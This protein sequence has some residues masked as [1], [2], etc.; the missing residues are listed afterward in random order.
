MF[1]LCLFKRSNSVSWS[2]KLNLLSFPLNSPSASPGRTVSSSF[3][4]L[5]CHLK[6]QNWKQT[7]RGRVTKAENKGMI[8]SFVWPLWHYC[9]EK[10]PTKSSNWLKTLKYF[11]KSYYWPTYATIFSLPILE[12]RKL[13]SIKCDSILV[14]FDHLQPLYAFL[15]YPDLWK[16]IGWLPSQQWDREKPDPPFL[17][18]DH[19]LKPGCVS[20]WK[21]YSHHFMITSNVLH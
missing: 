2:W 4:S 1:S 5:A 8:I 15:S 9:C 14:H 7:F 10:W 13:H 3:P 21:G 12:I 11:L 20:F 6:M 18:Q 17:I 19:F 16:L